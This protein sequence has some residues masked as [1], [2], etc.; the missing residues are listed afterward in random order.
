[1]PLAPALAHAAT[2]R[3]S[4]MTALS[5]GATVR[6]SLPVSHAQ[7]LAAPARSGVFQR[8]GSTMPAASAPAAATGAGLAIPRAPR[9]PGSDLMAMYN[10][11]GDVF[12]K[13]AALRRR[14][15]ADAR[16]RFGLA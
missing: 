4:M 11:F 12:G 7:T 3:P 9:A 16:L 15:V 13:E 8:A 14:A 10:R 6:P 2:M 5:H 1:M